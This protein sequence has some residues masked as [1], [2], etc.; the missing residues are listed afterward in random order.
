MKIG[1]EVRIAELEDYTYNPEFPS[2]KP[3]SAGYVTGIWT[4]PYRADDVQYIVK[5]NDGEFPF[6]RHEIAEVRK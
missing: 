3:G 5:L 2:L 6:Y 4:H 1:T